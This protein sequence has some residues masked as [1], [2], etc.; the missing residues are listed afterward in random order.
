MTNNDNIAINDHYHDQQIWQKSS[1]FIN[2][3]QNHHHHHHNNNDNQ[4]NRSI[5]MIDNETN[6][7]Y[8]KL[9]EIRTKSNDIII[10]V[11]LKMIDTLKFIIWLLPLSFMFEMKRSQQKSNQHQLN[12]H[13]HH[14]QN[15]HRPYH[16]RSRSSSS[17]STIS[18]IDHQQQLMSIIIII[19]LIIQQS[20]LTMSCGPGRGGS[21]RRSPRK[22]IPLVFKQHVPNVSENTLGASGLNEGPITRNHR[23]FKELVPNY[24]QDILFKDEEGT[25][26]D[27]LMT[28]RL[29]EK[30]NTLAISVMN[31]W[32]GVRLRVTEGWDEDGSHASNS[33]HYEGRAVDITTSDRDR[34][35][36][37][38]LARLA[39]EAGFDWVYYESRFHIHCSVKSEKS[40]SARNGGCFDQNSTVIG[41]NGQTINIDNL[42]IGDEILTMNPATGHLEY[43]SIIMFL[44][45]NPSI[46]RL[47]YEIETEF[48]RMITATPSHLLFISD[49]GNIDDKHEEFV[50]KIEMNQYLFVVMNQSDNQ[51]KSVAAAVAETTPRLE[52]IIRISTKKSKG[53]YAPLTVTGTIVV[54]NIVA[55]CYAIINSQQLSHL[56]F[57]P[58]RWLYQFIKFGDY[59]SQQLHVHHSQLIIRTTKQS[60]QSPS[61]SSLPIGIHWYPRLLYTMFNYF[62]PNDYIYQ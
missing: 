32:P 62:I 35:K 21:R 51:N 53:I 40:E 10:N 43:S 16:H 29:K 12:S 45:R 3:N 30:L 11:R 26:A 37:G 7:Q 20:Q 8:N 19:M 33:L 27:R 5:I 23:R 54:N 52:R 2:N 61:P 24:N 38:M 58:I 36:Y 57:I 44:D 50:S 13:H 34:S 28:Q 25:G 56:S 22:L 41:H 48:G 14:H 42:R 39:V 46:E 18:I 31:Q 9:N 59:L 17:S 55:S 47:Y 6:H 49:T 1:N 60:D 15:H 4:C